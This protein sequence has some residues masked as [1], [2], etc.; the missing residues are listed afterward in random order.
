MLMTSTTETFLTAKLL[1]QGYRYNNIQKAFSKFYSIHSELIVKKKIG[2][3]LFYN[4]AYL[5]RYF[6]VI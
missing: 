6:M 5:N 4:M 3:K 1:K 2:L